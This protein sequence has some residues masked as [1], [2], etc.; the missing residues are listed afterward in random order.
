MKGQSI[1][2][3]GLFYQHEI[4]TAADGTFSDTFEIDYK[5]SFT[6]LTR[7]ASMTVYFA[8][9]S[10]VSV[11]ADDEAF[12]NTVKFSGDLHLE[13]Q[14]LGAKMAQQNTINLNELFLLDETDFLKRIEAI[15]SQALSD[16]RRFN[17]SADFA[18]REERSIQFEYQFYLFRYEG[19]ARGRN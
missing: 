7:S 15:R 2:L 12:I 19:G 14:Y 4:P 9:G 17:F 5:G 6:L 1:V 10:S 3:R 18:F 13:N 11:T 16:F 8:P